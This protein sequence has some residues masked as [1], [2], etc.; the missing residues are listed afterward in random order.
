M[1]T[2][3]LTF[4][5]DV[6]EEW[7]EWA[8]RGAALLLMLL[9]NAFMLHHYVRALAEAGTLAGTVVNVG[10]NVACSS[11]MG[12]SLFGEALPARWWAGA[13]LTLLGVYCIQRGSAQQGQQQHGPGKAK[14]S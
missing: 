10:A 6:P 11:I 5:A 4:L 8:V 14:S 3:R 2:K 1:A 9:V 13:T 12:A 7:L